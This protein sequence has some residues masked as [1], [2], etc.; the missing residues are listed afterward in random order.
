MSIKKSERD[1]GSLD[2]NASSVKDQE[3][4]QVKNAFENVNELKDIINELNQ[5]LNINRNKNEETNKMNSMNI[6][7]NKNISDSQIKSQQKLSNNKEDKESSKSPKESNQTLNLAKNIKEESDLVNDLDT[8]LS[9][10]IVKSEEQIDDQTSSINSIQQ[11][12]SISS[13]QED[14]DNDFELISSNDQFDFEDSTNLN[15][16]NS[17]LDSNISS[18]SDKIYSNQSDHFTKMNTFNKPNPKTSQ[19]NQQSFK[20]NNLV[21]RNS[22]N[23]LKDTFK[24]KENKLKLFH[25]KSA[26]LIDQK[27]QTWQKQLLQT[28]FFKSFN[29]QQILSHYNNNLQNLELPDK[30]LNQDD[31]DPDEPLL[32]GSGEVPKECSDELIQSWSAILSK[33]KKPNQRPPGLKDLIK[34]GIPETLRGQVW[35]VIKILNYQLQL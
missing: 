24:S 32:S 6:I 3:D 22:Q 17:N 30:I 1:E 33:W 18:T 35:Q 19:E 8:H 15:S 26:E 10:D 34:F 21:K 4:L 13:D 29:T 9:K 25:H 11:Q 23:N 12:S 31:S 16:N 28:Q 5:D 2:E 20:G 14:K 27:K 7:L